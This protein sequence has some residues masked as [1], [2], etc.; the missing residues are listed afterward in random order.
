MCPNV[1]V[2]NLLQRAIGGAHDTDCPDRPA[3][4]GELA[5]QRGQRG[6]RNAL[7]SRHRGAHR[8]DGLLPWELHDLVI[9]LS[10]LRNRRIDEGDLAPPQ[11]LRRFRRSPDR[12]RDRSAGFGPKADGRGAAHEYGS[13]SPSR[14]RQ[15]AEGRGQKWSP[16]AH[17]IRALSYANRLLPSLI[18]TELLTAG[19]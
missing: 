4:G 3:S 19:F 2:A 10:R 5:N 6:S 11:Q 17:T 12:D 14:G 7:D 15:K 1:L 13:V 8:Y 18:S 9:R 16:L